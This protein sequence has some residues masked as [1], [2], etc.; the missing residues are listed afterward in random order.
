[1]ADAEQR[2]RRS[3]LD[4]LDLAF[5][6]REA[7]GAIARRGAVWLRMRI[8][9]NL[10]AIVLALV[11][12]YG[13]LVL[14]WGPE[15]AIAMMFGGLAIAWLG[16]AVLWAF[17]RRAAAVAAGREIDDRAVWAIVDTLRG[18]TD[19]PRRVGGDLPLG[20]SLVAD[21]IGLA[22]ATALVTRAWEARGFGIGELLE[23]PGLVVGL[24]ITAIA[25][26]PAQVGRLVSPAEAIVLPR[27]RSGQRGIGIV[28]LVFALMAAGGGTFSPVLL[29]AIAAGL[30]GGIA[31]LDLGAT[32][33]AERV[34]CEWLARDVARRRAET[35]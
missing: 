12:L 5:L 8:V 21:A 32:L 25:A 9:S 35:S 17:R 19:S 30:V 33:P 11:T 7:P 13:L 28:V 15:L 23:E 16:D 31:L 20:V 34:A 24:A 4:P 1:M 27:A 14:G 26:L 22:V 2:D 29:P 10:E 18:R 3:K 6:G